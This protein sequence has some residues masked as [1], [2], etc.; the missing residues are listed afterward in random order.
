MRAVRDLSVHGSLRLR[1]PCLAGHGA[2]LPGR[3]SRGRAVALATAVVVHRP[4][5]RRSRR[6][7]QNFVEQWLGLDALNHVNADQKF[8]LTQP[9]KEDMR[10]EPIAFFEN[11]LK[12]NS[13]IMDFI[14]SDY[15]VINERLAQRYEIKEVFGQEFRRVKVDNASHRGGV[16]TS[17]AVL[18]MNANGVDSSPLARGVWMLKR[19][20]NDP[21]PPPPPN[22]PEVDLTDPKILE[23]TQK[24]RMADHRNKPACISCHAKIDPWGVAF[25]HFDAVG[26][27]RTTIKDKPVDAAA[28]LF[29]GHKLD[30]VDG[31]KRYLMNSRKDQF[32]RA[33]VHKLTS[34]ALGRPLSFADRHETD[35]MT[36]ELR[37]KGDGLRDLIRIVIKGDLFTAKNATGAGD[38]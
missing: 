36:T 6:F 19:I 30:G 9:D 18:T 11:S 38:E 13:S 26:N 33:M 20:L 8:H 7:A 16:L 21:P 25:E 31:V 14:H 34:Y 3:D 22:V 10:E 15:V 1:W 5:H 29:N 32:A 23:M 37:E 27:Y 17:A 12:S 28:V 24:E 4:F 2:L 35:K